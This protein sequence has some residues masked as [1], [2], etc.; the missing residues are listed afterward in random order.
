MIAVRW[1]RALLFT[2]LLSM[3]GVAAVAVEESEVPVVSTAA[4]WVSRGD[5]RLHVW[6]KFVGSPSGKPVVILAHGSSTA[7]R[8]SFDLA[9]PERSGYSLMDRFAR[10]GFDVFALDVHGFGRSTRPDGYVTTDGAAADLDAVV[11]AVRRARNVP[12]VHLVAWSWGTQYAG[13]FVTAHAEK[14]GRFVSYAQMHADSPDIVRRRADLEL[15]RSRPWIVVPRDGWKARFRS[16]TPAD[17]T[18]PEV[19]EAF[20]DAAAAIETRTATGPQLDMVTRLP[21]VDPARITVPTLMIHGQYDDVADTT[22]LLPFFARL[23]NPDK[24]YVVIPRAGHM[25]H[26]QAGRHAF[27]DAVVDFLRAR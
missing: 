12:R 13:L 11:D 15:Y 19:M 27:F 4:H 3:P 20:A 2:T 21:M 24:R 9:V 16:L 10:A 8:E 22:G 18:E 7:G 25:L 26:L 23:P 17:V 5:A 6:E 14:V 1:V